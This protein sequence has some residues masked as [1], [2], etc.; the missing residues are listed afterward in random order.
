MHI[1]GALGAILDTSLSSTPRSVQPSAEPCSILPCPPSGSEAQGSYTRLSIG[2]E[3]VRSL[4]G[5]VLVAIAIELSPGD[6]ENADSAKKWISCSKK[7]QS[8]FYHV[9]QRAKRQHLSHSPTRS[10]WQTWP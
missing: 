2:G 7:K 6:A 8:F 5:R 4:P 3:I 10:R 9:L 1:F